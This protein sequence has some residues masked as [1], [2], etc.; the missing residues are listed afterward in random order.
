MPDD[1]SHPPEPSRDDPLDPTDQLDVEAVLA[2]ASGLSS[3]LSS[4]IGT[5]DPN[6]GAGGGEAGVNVQDVEARLGEVEHLLAEVA[7][8]ETAES[9]DTPEESE[10]DRGETASEGPPKD[11]EAETS[12][13]TVAEPSPE[14]PDTKTGGEHATN[15]AAGA[16]AGDEASEIVSEAADASERATPIEP[17]PESAV[18]TPMRG[19]VGA[20]LRS[21]GEATTSRA[22]AM[23]EL[24]V[25]ALLGALDTMDRVFSWIN[26][27]ARRIIG[28]IALVIFTAACTITFYSFSH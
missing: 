12:A 28:W 21:I 14:G 4:E 2:E 17:A 19:T 20:K 26:L 3:K 22:R 18:N 23:L 1:P 25:R 11:K 10:S 13:V 7:G 16:A 15:A 27:G 8:G 24:T 9:A 5:A 6:V